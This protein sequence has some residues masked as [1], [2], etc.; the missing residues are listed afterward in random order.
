VNI[1]AIESSNTNVLLGT[2]VAAQP[3]ASGDTASSKPTLSMENVKFKSVGNDG[4]A[5]ED[6]SIHKTDTAAV[7]VSSTTKKDTKSSF[8]LGG[9]GSADSDDLHQIQ[10]NRAA[11]SG[12]RAAG[13][14]TA[15]RQSTETLNQND[16]LGTEK[17]NQNSTHRNVGDA[18]MNKAGQFKDLLTR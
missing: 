18:I 15:V 9:E 12:T 13:E 4:K 10:N 3:T 7:K 14:R 1:P 8:E 5:I 6:N 11:Y 16:T 2:P 17:L